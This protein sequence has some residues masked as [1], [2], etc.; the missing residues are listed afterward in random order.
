[1]KERYQQALEHPLHRACEL[2]LIHAADGNSELRFAVNDF[3]T[4]P[5]GTLHGGILYALMDVACFFAASTLLKPDQ[6]VVTV[7]THSSVLRAA[8][9]G[10]HVIIRAHTDRLGRTLAAIRVEAHAV[11]QSGQE[12][13]IATGSVTK[14]VIALA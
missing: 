6:H 13:L 2:E 11:D 14:S 1:M 8:Q 9:Q 4:N 10:E 7:E 5:I 3:C 12:R